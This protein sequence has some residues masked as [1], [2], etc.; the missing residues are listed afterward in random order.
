MFIKTKILSNFLRH[1][2]QYTEAKINKFTEYLSKLILSE[3]F[4]AHKKLI[5]NNL[6]RIDAKFRL[7]KENYL[8]F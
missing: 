1:K 4:T 6:S 3:V 8:D 7:S 5:D 2:R